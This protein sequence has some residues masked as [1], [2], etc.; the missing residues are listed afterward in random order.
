M[1]KYSSKDQEALNAIIEEKVCGVVADHE[2][3][4]IVNYLYNEQ[5][6]TRLRILLG[7]ECEQAHDRR[8]SEVSDPRQHFE[9]KSEFINGEIDLKVMQFLN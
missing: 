4:D 7:V 2:Y 3:M 1:N 6:A 5:D 9:F 8:G